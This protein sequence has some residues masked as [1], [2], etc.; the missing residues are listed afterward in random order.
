MS[1]PQEHKGQGPSFSDSPE[2]I[3]PQGEVHTTVGDALDRAEREGFQRERSQDISLPP[4]PE[5]KKANTAHLP[6]MIAHKE[7]KKENQAVSDSSDRDALEDYEQTRFL[8]GTSGEASYPIE[9][10]AMPKRRRKRLATAPD[11]PIQK[12]LDFRSEDELGAYCPIPNPAHYRPKSPNA[13]EE[14]SLS[15]QVDNQSVTQDDPPQ[16]APQPE[17]DEHGVPVLPDPIKRTQRMEALAKKREKALRETRRQQKRQKVFLSQMRWILRMSI[18]VAIGFGL[19][20]LSQWDALYWVQPQYT[21]NNAKLLTPKDINP[22]LDAYKGDALLQIDPEQIEKAIA[23]KFK[24]VDRVYVRRQLFPSQLNLHFMEK[25]AWA[26][27][28]ESPEAPRPYALLTQGY[29]K[30]YY[31]IEL[32]NYHFAVNQLGALPKV[33]VPQHVGLKTH[34]LGKLDP[35]L[36]QLNHIPGMHFLYLDSTQPDFLVAHFQEAKVILGRLDAHWQERLARIVP[37]APKLPLLQKQFDSVDLR[38]TKQVTLH[39]KSKPAQ[40]GD[41]D[42]AKELAKNPPEVATSPVQQDPTRPG[43]TD[44]T[45]TQTQ[46]SSGVALQNPTS[47]NAT[48]HNR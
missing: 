16:E 4:L 14:T 32:Q 25:T 33:V 39:Q 26:E 20:A 10:N 24:M 17:L 44:N 48:P 19:W 7:T 29:D 8:A 22:L 37:L 42:P 21:L 40:A 6:A 11:K 3:G 30:K 31:L 34:F 46:S 45:G 43:L 12:R 13:S 15:T 47:S 28:Y 27:V 9:T 36:Y 38:W 35:V 5:R 1:Y 23:Q 18:A 2:T 41:T